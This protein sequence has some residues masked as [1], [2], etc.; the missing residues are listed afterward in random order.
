MINL[1][2]LSENSVLNNLRIRYRKE[3][4]YVSTCTLR[5]VDGVWLGVDHG[6][7][8]GHT[9][10]DVHGQHSCGGQPVQVDQHLRGRRCQRALV[11]AHPVLTRALALALAVARVTVG[12]RQAVQPGAH[13]RPAAAHFR[14]CRSVLLQYAHHER[15]PV[16]H[17]LWFVSGPGIV[18]PRTLTT[19]WP[20]AQASRA[21]ARPSRPS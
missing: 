4:I 12:G 1:P 13:W 5:S 18:A 2:E 6:E 20:H 8:A 14:D 7:G 21:P 15:E 11:Q 9:A 10:T 19:A 16:G 17:Y 3:I